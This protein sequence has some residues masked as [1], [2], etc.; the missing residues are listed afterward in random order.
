MLDLNP[1]TLINTL[2]VNCLNTPIKRQ[3]KEQTKYMLSMYMD[4]LK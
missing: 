2:N 3:I 4:T 1:T